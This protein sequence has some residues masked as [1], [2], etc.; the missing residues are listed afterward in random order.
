MVNKNIN[1]KEVFETQIVDVA[2]L[3][4]V[5]QNLHEKGYKVEHVLVISTSGNNARIAIV[6]SHIE[7]VI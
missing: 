3:A 2:C 5:L 4:P 1:L 7:K 6:Y